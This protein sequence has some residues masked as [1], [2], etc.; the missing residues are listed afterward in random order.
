MT[1][2]GG[3][4]WLVGR[5][6]QASR[7]VEGPTI[8]SNHSQAS[9]LCILPTPHSQT[10]QTSPGTNPRSALTLLKEYTVIAEAAMMPTPTTTAAGHTADP[11]ASNFRENLAAVYIEENGAG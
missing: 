10:A 1:M 5:G 7:P 8:F 6:C 3:Y 2:T 9:L 11:V 4:G